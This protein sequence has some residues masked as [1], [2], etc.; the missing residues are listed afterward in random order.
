MVLLQHSKAHFEE[1]ILANILSLL[2]TQLDQIEL[3]CGRFSEK[4]VLKESK[5][6]V[7]WLGE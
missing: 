7:Y 5:N 3:C 6:P 4:Y 1:K 2:M